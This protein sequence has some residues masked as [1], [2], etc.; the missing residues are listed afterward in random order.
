MSNIIIWGKTRELISGQLPP[1][2]SSRE[3][4]TL[5]ELKKHLD[6]KGGTLVLVHP[7]H[8]DSEGAALAE[9]LDDGGKLQALFVAVA[10]AEEADSLLERYGF[11][12]DL[13]IKPVTPARIRLR[14]DKGLDAI[15][16]RRVIA[17]LDSALVRKSEELNALNKIGVALS[18]ERDIRKLLEL[19]LDKSR[20]ITASDAGSLYLVKRGKDPASSVDDQLHFTLARNDSLPEYRFEERTMPLD[21]GSIA[22]YVALSGEPVNVADAYN[23]PAGSTYQISRA[24]D[25]RSGYKT[26]SVLVVP[27]KDHQDKVVGVVQLI[28]KKREPGTVL[29]PVSLVDEAVIPFTAVDQELVTSLASQAAV[30]FE[31]T[32]LIQD[33][34]NLFESFVD[35]SVSAIESRDPTTSGHSTRVAELTVGIAEKVDT[36]ETGPFKDVSFT[37]D[38]LQEIKYASLLHDFGKVG[39]REKVLI[40]GKKLYVGEM[41]L[42]RQRIAYIKRTLEAENLRTKLDQA[43]T[44]PAS[45]E[46][47]SQIDRDYDLRR[48][49][50]EQIQRMVLQANEPTILE[51]ESFRALMDLPK[52]TFADIDGNRQPFLTPNEVQALSIRRGSLSE[53]ERREIESHVTHTFKF[54]SQIPWTGEF[55][56]VP[57]IAY[58][59]HEKL[60]GTG[61]PRKLTAAEI[62]I[63]SK[64]MTISD[65]YDALVAWDRPYKKSVPIEKALNILH[66]EASAGKLDTGLLQLFIEAKIYEKTLPKAGAE[67]QVVR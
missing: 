31:N 54:L 2:V 62:P 38:Q 58:A 65:I 7:G 19:I 10:E 27:M 37:R 63:Q 33:M 39:V 26:K 18:A 13:L 6:S 47:L 57:E 28:N 52:R 53:K 36:L 64:M 9:W 32:L 42:I 66:E 43:L 44:D 35:A 51:E 8:L 15:H 55:S 1:G 29:R 56:R 48:E 30:A 25:Q 22:G 49:E 17:Q 12:D 50:I 46:L 41:L 61:Y 40:K 16:S 14:L 24:F 3:V 59:H 5:A 23:L 11:L 20:E 60:D 21:K 45:K 34:R 4:A 67:T